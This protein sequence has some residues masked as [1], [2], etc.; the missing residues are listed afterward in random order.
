[1]VKNSP[2][3][4]SIDLDG[5]TYVLRKE[6]TGE[7]YMEIRRRSIAVKVSSDGLAPGDI[8]KEISSDDEETRKRAEERLK[9]EVNEMEFDFW[10]LVARLEKP[11]FT[12][13]EI[14]ALPRHVFQVL[15][16]LA[17]RID[18]EEAAKVSDFLRQNSQ[19]FQVSQSTSE[20]S[21]DFPQPTSEAIPD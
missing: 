7:Q 20:P 9:I 21:S 14:K 13:E 5:V 12:P 2:G 19:R 3:T 17:S 11:S 8:L 4:E 16:M 15:T 6:T 1:M 10:N 18:A